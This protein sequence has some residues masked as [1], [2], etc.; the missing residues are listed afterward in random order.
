MTEK[1][2]KDLA[3]QER[4]A[5]IIADAVE[6]YKERSFVL[7]YATTATAAAATSWTAQVIS[8][9]S[10]A[11][12]G[13][14]LVY[15]A[16]NS[17][18]GV[19]VA[20]TLGVATGA[21]GALL[22]ELIKKDATRQILIGIFSRKGSGL[23]PKLLFW[24][25]FG[26]SISVSSLGADL[27]AEIAEPPAGVYIP[28]F[29]EAKAE[30]AKQYTELENSYKYK[31]KINNKDK[32]YLKAE[33]DKLQKFDELEA[34]ERESWAKAEE[35]KK[36]K[37]SKYANLQFYTVVCF[38]FLFLLANAFIF[39]YKEKSRKVAGQTQNI[40][41]LQAP[42]NT[43]PPIIPT[44]SPTTPNGGHPAPPAAST[45]LDIL[46]MT[47][48]AKLKSLFATYRHNLKNANSEHAKKQ[49]TDKLQMIAQRLAELGETPPVD[50]GET[51]TPT[52]QIGF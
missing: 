36:G 33:K 18:L 23:V 28:K 7:S 21:A 27:A 49:N 15:L 34:A 44:A 37:F 4:E 9:I 35:A 25:G 29:A 41:S 26:L 48:I 3:E 2:I 47:N 17:T 51:N 20:A 24:G 42:T 8:F 1:Q 50:R 13:G 40:I 16:T 10:A 5:A 12:F 22:L 39:W 52:R 30:A 31:G 43:P 11:S 38:E 19:G 45:N 46:N 6:T 32:P 14:G